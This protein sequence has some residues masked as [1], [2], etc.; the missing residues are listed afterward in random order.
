MRMS[1]KI[2]SW[3]CNCSRWKFKVWRL[4]WL[5]VSIPLSVTN[6][7]N[8]FAVLYELSKH[9]FVKKQIRNTNLFFISEN[10]SLYLRNPNILMRFYQ[11]EI[12]ELLNMPLLHFIEFLTYFLREEL[13][14]SIHFLIQL[15]I[16][17]NHWYLTR[18]VKKWYIACKI[19]ERKRS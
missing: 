4:S 12:S 3:R 9:N 11:D 14:I 7:E 16:N 5:Q 6:D 13:T 17:I 2:L 18:Q 15:R 19:Q 8:A 1:K 10:F